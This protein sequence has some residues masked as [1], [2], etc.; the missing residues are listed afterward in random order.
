MR[1]A[2]GHIVRVPTVHTRPLVC[3]KPSLDISIEAALTSH[4]W[5]RAYAIVVYPSC[6]ANILGLCKVTF[7]VGVTGQNLIPTISAVP[8]YSKSETRC[9]AQIACKVSP[10][11]LT[12]TTELRTVTPG[13]LPCKESSS[14]HSKGRLLAQALPRPC[15]IE[16]SAR[17]LT[18]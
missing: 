13:Q 10:H 9:P 2:R 4:A 12:S 11:I 1:A 5:F 8:G 18:V 17:S 16:H 6:G 14:Q 7:L 15:V 3:G